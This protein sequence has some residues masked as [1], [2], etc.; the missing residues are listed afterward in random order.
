MPINLGIVCKRSLSEWLS[1][2]LTLV[3]VKPK[4]LAGRESLARFLLAGLGDVS[5]HSITTLDV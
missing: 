3:T 2:A 4:T 5:V 1:D